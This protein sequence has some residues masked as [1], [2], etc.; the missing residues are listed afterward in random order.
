MLLE[1]SARRETISVNA[2]G[3]IVYLDFRLRRDFVWQF[4][5]A[6]VTMP[7]LG[8]DFLVYYRLLRMLGE[9]D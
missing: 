5:L 9:T 2:F 8:I 4:V 6:D 1:T 3:S 7:I